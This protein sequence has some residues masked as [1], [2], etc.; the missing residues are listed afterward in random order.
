MSVMTNGFC[1]E[2]VT[3][4]LKTLPLT[5]VYATI[6]DKCVSTGAFENIGQYMRVDTNRD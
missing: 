3:S 1:N 2:H 4:S 6:A 5:T